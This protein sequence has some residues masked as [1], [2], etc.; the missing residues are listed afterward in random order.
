MSNSTVLHFTKSLVG[1]V[2]SG[3]VSLNGGEMK[4]LLAVLLLFG[5][6]V[7]RADGFDIFGNATAYWNT[8][9]VTTAPG[10]SISWLG[11]S[12]Q[13]EALQF[14]N[15]A[16]GSTTVADQSNPDWNP[17]SYSNQMDGAVASGKATAKSLSSSILW[18]GSRLDGQPPLSGTDWMNVQRGGNFLVT[19]SGDVTFTMHYSLDAD[20]SVNTSLLPY[21]FIETGGFAEADLLL[22]IPYVQTF[23]YDQHFLTIPTVV[24]SDKDFLSQTGTATVSSYLTSGQYWIQGESHS[25]V[26]VEAPEPSSLTLLGFGLFGVLLLWTKLKIFC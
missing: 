10:V 19:G 4:Y 6:G 12:N 2:K 7:A 9:T 18:S 8:L 1:T 22:Y 15:T 3:E 20:R 26:T 11:T 13:T 5:C 24:G 14:F 17:L 21:P 25:L 23:D 16:T